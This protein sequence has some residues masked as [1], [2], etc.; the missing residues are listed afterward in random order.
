MKSILQIEDDK[1]LNSDITLRLTKEGYQMY[2]AEGVTEAGNLFESHMID[3]II[4]GVMLED[5]NGL[6]FAGKCGKRAMCT[7]F[8]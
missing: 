4:S 3:L 8:S 1:N 2:S 5:G 7:L 6:E